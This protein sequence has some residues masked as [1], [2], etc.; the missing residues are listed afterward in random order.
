V[1]KI[2]EIEGIPNQD[3]TLELI[4][5]EYN[6]KYYVYS[7]SGRKATGVY[8]NTVYLEYKLDTGVLLDSG[9]Y[10][11]D[12]IWYLPINDSMLANA[13][14]Y[15]KNIWD[16][17]E[18]DRDKYKN[19]TIETLESAP[20][21]DEWAVIESTDSEH[22]IAGYIGLRSYDSGIARCPIKIKEIYDPS[23]TNNKVLCKNYRKLKGEM[24][25][26]QVLSKEF[27]GFEF[28][29]YAQ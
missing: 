6:G 21:G 2:K 14:E 27:D 5:P 4:D 23:F 16:P 12:V 8:L 29:Y 13:E 1:F 18:V 15:I 3:S 22:Y 11:D 10:D 20:L 7:T 19:E 9:R 24:N 28:G 25:T 26:S 17:S